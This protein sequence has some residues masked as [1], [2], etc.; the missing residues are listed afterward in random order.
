MR[1]EAW[2]IRLV[3]GITAASS[4]ALIPVAASATTGRSSNASSHAVSVFT[5][6]G[7][8]VGITPTPDG[9]GYLTITDEGWVSAYGDASFASGEVGGP[10]P[11]VG[12]EMGADSGGFWTVRADGGVFTIGDTA[13]YG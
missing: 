4:I 10:A 12:I 13:F 5:P 3:L 8:V 2:K 6:L 9:G 11:V 7:N 1:R